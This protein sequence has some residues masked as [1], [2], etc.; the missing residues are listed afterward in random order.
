MNSPSPSDVSP[1]ARD[2]RTGQA[3]LEDFALAPELTHLNHGSYGAVP[4]S[5]LA[6]QECI[7]REVERNPTGFFSEVY[8]RGVRQAAAVAAEYFGGRVDDWVFCENATSA[9]NSVLAS[10]PLRAGD[11]LLTTS[12][13]YGAVLRAMRL[14]A[15]R[16][17]ATLRIAEVPAVVESQSQVAEA[18]AG[19]LTARTRL[20]VVDHITSPTATVFPVAEIVRRAHD[21]G[22]PVLVD[23]AHAPGQL[24]LNVP[25]IAADWYTGN[26]HKWFFAPRGCGV[27]WTARKWQAITRPAV[28]SHGTDQG[29]TAAFDWI[30]TRDASPW[31]SL[32]KAAEAFDRFGGAALMARNRALAAAAANH[33]AE[34]TKG[35][36]TAPTSMRPAMA[37]VRLS[38]A[39]DLE[40][41]IKVRRKLAEGGFVI[42]TNAFGGQLCIRISAQIYNDR[43]DYDR[44]ADALLSLGIPLQ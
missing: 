41:A 18:I 40:G 27:L 5:V 31:L 9:I 32:P 13:A 4:N 19:A 43:I 42:A 3:A 28:L 26:A 2:L 11:E 37:T 14:W 25:E 7:R 12:H 16:N 1:T 21:A 38:Q 34:R 30:G 17:G 20:L 6:E 15:E 10:L 33:I 36:L 29:Y 22:I 44:F 23:G 39:A 35:V 24:A 8:P